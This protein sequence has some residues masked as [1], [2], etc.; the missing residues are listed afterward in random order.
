MLTSR[1]GSLVSA[2]GAGCGFGLLRLGVQQLEEEKFEEKPRKHRKKRRILF[3]G[4]ALAILLLHSLMHFT[5]FLFHVV[6][7]CAGK[8]KCGQTS[9][10]IESGEREVA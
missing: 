9:A 7:L 10:E 2:Q 5:F 8:K 1:L 4:S 3:V 6:L